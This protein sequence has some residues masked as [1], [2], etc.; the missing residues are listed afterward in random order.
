MCVLFIVEEKK[1]MILIIINCIYVFIFISY[2]NILKSMKS[3]YLNYIIKV[4]EN[5]CIHLGL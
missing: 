3:I 1:N 4:N 5:N 2:Y